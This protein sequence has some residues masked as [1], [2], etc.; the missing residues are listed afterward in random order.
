[1]KNVRFASRERKLRSNS[2]VLHGAGAP[3]HRSRKASASYSRSEC[4]IDKALNL[5]YNSIGSTV[6]DVTA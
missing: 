2:R 3:L 5:W 6:K 1:M 4:F